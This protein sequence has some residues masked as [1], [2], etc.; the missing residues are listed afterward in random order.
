MTDVQTVYFHNTHEKRKRHKIVKT[1]CTRKVIDSRKQF[2]VNV[3]KHLNF[4]T[5]IKILDIENKKRRYKVKF[6]KMYFRSS[7]EKSLYF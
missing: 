3:N 5:F 4:A 6:N 1:I 2:R 7:K